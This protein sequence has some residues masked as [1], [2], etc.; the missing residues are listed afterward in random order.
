[1]ENK[2]KMKFQKTQGQIK[3]TSKYIKLYPVF[4]VLLKQ[5]LL[6]GPERLNFVII[7]PNVKQFLI[8]NQKG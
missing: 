8:R 7:L 5:V 1:M 4:G 3:I 6:P 2:N